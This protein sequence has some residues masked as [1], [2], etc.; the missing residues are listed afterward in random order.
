M[1][2]SIQYTLFCT[3]Q[4]QLRYQMLHQCFQN[5]SG[6]VTKGNGWCPM[7]YGVLQVHPT[8]K[9]FIKGQLCIYHVF[10]GQVD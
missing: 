9:A 10:V 5:Y 1:N 2:G 7:Q 8:L 6:N 3:A 4:H